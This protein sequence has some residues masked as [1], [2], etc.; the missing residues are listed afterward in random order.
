MLTFQQKRSASELFHTAFL[1]RKPLALRPPVSAWMVPP[2]SCLLCC[3]MCSPAVGGETT[4]AA[5]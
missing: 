3:C 5:D 4:A 2:C 1:L